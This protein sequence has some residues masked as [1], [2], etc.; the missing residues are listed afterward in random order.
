MGSLEKRLK[1][2]GFNTDD[3]GEG[4]SI[5]VWDK[6][7]RVEENLYYW[8]GEPVITR[9]KPLKKGIPTVVE[10][11]CGCGGTSVGFEMAG[12]QIAVG[13]D[14]HKPSI[15]TYA[16]NHP[17]A[18][19]ILGDVKRIEP[20]QILE[21]MCG[22]QVD[23]LIAGV[24]C[25]GFSLNNRKRHQGDERNLLYKEFVRFVKA[26]KPNAIVLENVSGM[27]STGDFVG[28]IERELSVASGME[29][30]SKMLFSHDYG[31]PQKRQ[32]LVFVGIR[33]AGDFD[34]DKVKKTHG[35]TTGR[36]YVNVKDA[37]G[38]LPSLQPGEAAD[39]YQSKPSSEYQKLMRGRVK[40]AL[41]NHVAPNH[42]RET[43]EKIRN[44]PPGRP[45]YPKFKQRIRLSWDILSPTQ[46]SGGI[47]PQ[48]QFGHPQD[49][50][51]LTIR[52]RCRLQSF[53][54]HFVVSGGIVQGRVQTGNAVPPLLARAVALAI[55]P[56]VIRWAGRAY[57]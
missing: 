33:G 1:A 26:L 27:R 11:F 17:G 32:R 48:F 30:K 57:I 9:G 13:A 18:S 8:K 47:R 38:D 23:V 22:M 50:R 45:M 42:P 36:A 21:L 19:T 35:P 10:L 24:P 20:G 40:G 25:Q 16:Q 14:I 4:A 46:V 37:I 51:G 31:V 53:P 3:E 54:D 34:F 5:N 44:T 55:K 39:R 28:Q 2:K 52:E 56:H 49:P 41:T 43:V 29:V 7:V 15:Q 12:F 6:T